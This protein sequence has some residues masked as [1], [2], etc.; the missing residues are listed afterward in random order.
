MKVWQ[1][2]MAPRKTPAAGSSVKNTEE[3]SSNQVQLEEA[4]AKQGPT[5]ATFSAPAGGEDLSSA[6]KQFQQNAA[7]R[8]FLMGNNVNIN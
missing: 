7:I 6:T 3:A 4:S 5:R 2:T 8:S 1:N